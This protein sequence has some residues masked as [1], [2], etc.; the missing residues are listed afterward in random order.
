MIRNYYK[1]K[2]CSCKGIRMIF[3]DIEMPVMD[4]F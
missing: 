4:G 2:K 3:M 1:N